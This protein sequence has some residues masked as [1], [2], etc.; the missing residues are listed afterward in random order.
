[1]DYYLLCFSFYIFLIFVLVFCVFLFFVLQ[2]NL[3]CVCIYDLVSH[4][5]LFFFVIHLLYNAT[6]GTEEESTTEF[7]YTNDTSGISGSTT[8]ASP[9][10]P[11][12]TNDPGTGGNNS[13]GLLSLT[14]TEIIL[15]AAIILVVLSLCICTMCFCSRKHKKGQKNKFGFGRKS[16]AASKK[17]A[18]HVEFVQ[19]SP[20]PQS[21]A[22][23]NSN[24]FPNGQTAGG[25]TPIGGISNTPGSHFGSGGNNEIVIRGETIATEDLPNLPRDSKPATAFHTPQYGQYTPAGGYGGMNMANEG[26]TIQRQP[27][28]ST[29]GIRMSIESDVSSIYDNPT[30]DGATANGNANLNTIRPPPPVQSVYSVQTPSG[31]PPNLPPRPGNY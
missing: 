13:S 21:P 11:S 10:P 5:N 19:A 7:P 22:V 24:G 26:G 17:N 20:A 25:T 27:L 3:F 2:S 12:N 1:M 31:P 14:T 29:D 18:G 8:T 6:G 30:D 15:L 9:S 4:C 23:S 16:L 28:N